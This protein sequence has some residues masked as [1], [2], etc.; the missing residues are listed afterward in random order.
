M[1]DFVYSKE[2]PHLLADLRKIYRWHA[3][4]PI[5]ENEWLVLKKK[6]KKKKK[7]IQK[8]LLQEV[9]TEMW[10]GKTPLSN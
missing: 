7:N 3:L 10:H 8:R 5:I 6:K 1:C 4:F 9:L 2:F